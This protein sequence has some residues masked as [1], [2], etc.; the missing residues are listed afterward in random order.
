M[1]KISF[2]IVLLLLFNFLPLYRTEAQNSPENR[3][4]VNMYLILDGSLAFSN[5]TDVTINEV[6]TWIIDRLDQ[7]LAEGDRITI[8]KAGT[9]AN[10]IYTGRINNSGDTDIT[11]I[12]ETVKKAIQELISGNDVSE[13]AD[14]SG[15]LQQAQLEALQ[16]QGSGFN[17]TL[18]ISASPASL[19]SILSGPQANLL[20]YSRIEEFTSWRALVVGLNLE[21]RVKRSAAAFFNN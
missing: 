18:L 8:W 21:T 14:F 10:I 3:P 12:K 13:N 2:I 15:A 19:T 16:R 1:K 6:T 4:P 9:R 11:S 20:R 5:S 7:I 17:Y